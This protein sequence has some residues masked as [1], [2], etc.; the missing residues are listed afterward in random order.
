[1]GDNR[2][3]LGGMSRAQAE[4]EAVHD[5]CDVLGVALPEEKP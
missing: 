3:Y 4:Q 1:M 5:T 2:E